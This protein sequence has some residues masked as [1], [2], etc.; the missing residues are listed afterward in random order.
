MK[1]VYRR[2]LSVIRVKLGRESGR[3]MG[4]VAL[5][6]RWGYLAVLVVNAMLVAGLGAYFVVENR[7]CLRGRQLIC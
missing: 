4:T 3:L 5:D 7:E 2:L 6:L 1:K